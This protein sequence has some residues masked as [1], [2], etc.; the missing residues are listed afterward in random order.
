MVA[1]A[2][3]RGIAVADATPSVSR[4]CTVNGL[5]LHVVDWQTNTDSL[6]M[7]LLHGAILQSHV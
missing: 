5:N 6:P 1:A 3:R 7:L 2:H 4:A